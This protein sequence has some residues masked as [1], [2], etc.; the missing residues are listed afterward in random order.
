V[1]SKTVT[2]LLNRAA[3]GD[4]IAAREVLP[5]VYHELRRL[6]SARMAKLPPGQTLQ[7][8]ALVHEAYL[9]VN[10]SQPLGYESRTQFFI[11]AARAMRDILV[12][13]ARRKSRIKHGGD[14]DRVELEDVGLVVETPVEDILALNQALDT[15]EIEDPEGHRIVMLRYFAGFSQSEVADA[16]G[17]SERTI[18]RRWR[19]LR[20]WLLQ[21]QASPRDGL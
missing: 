14:L 10:E 19:F 17:V 12:D 3:E 21:H 13:A 8:T 16:L 1:E 4:R 2:V 6:A 11:F 7:A 15:L 5:L 9:A 18:E 20:A